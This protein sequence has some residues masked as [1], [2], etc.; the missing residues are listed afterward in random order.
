[1]AVARWKDLCIDASDAGR[2]AEFWGAALGLRVERLD[3]GDAVLRGDVPTETIWINQVPEPKSVKHRVHI[4]VRAREIEPL[5]ALGAT[6]LSPAAESGRPWT[7]MSDPE[8]GEFCVFLRD[9][10]GTDPAARLYALVVDTA[11]GPSSEAIAGW[12]ADVLG[13]RR[14]D[15]GRGFWWAEGAPGLPFESIDFVPVPEPKA[16]KNRLHWDVESDDLDSLVAAG[17]VVLAEP[18][19]S[20]PWHVCA[21]PDGNEFCVFAPSDR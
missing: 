2:I 19:D 12:W 3:D 10:L 9:V 1:M 16:V 5:V 6:V 21:D 4:D 17:A 11:D 18:T 15:D 7:V 14:D 20:T 13:G 8:G